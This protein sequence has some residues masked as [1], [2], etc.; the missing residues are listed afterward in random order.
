MMS[1]INGL[2]I[3]SQR[4]MFVAKGPCVSIELF[5]LSCDEELFFRKV[6]LLTERVVEPPASTA[7]SLERGVVR[8]LLRSIQKSSDRLVVTLREAA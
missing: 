5:F 1:P 6:L 2:S 8:S 7:V 4:A 3:V